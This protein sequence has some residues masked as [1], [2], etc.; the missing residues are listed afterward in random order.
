LQTVSKNQCFKVPFDKLWVAI[1]IFGLCSHTQKQRT[2][3]VWH[4]F[5]QKSSM[6]QLMSDANVSVREFV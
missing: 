1:A 3:D 2:I 5:K 6:T 4:R